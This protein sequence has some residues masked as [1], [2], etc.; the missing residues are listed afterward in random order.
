M[1]DLLDLLRGSANMLWMRLSFTFLMLFLFCSSNLDMF[2]WE[3]EID[4][5]SIY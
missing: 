2:F 5:F 3:Q 4:A 1:T